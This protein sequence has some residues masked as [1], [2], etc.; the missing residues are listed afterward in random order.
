MCVRVC[1]CACGVGGVC[2]GHGQR[3][4]RVSFCARDPALDFFVSRCLVLSLISLTYTY[5]LSL[6]FSPSLSLTH[7]GGTLENLLEK[8]C[9]GRILE[10]D[11]ARFCISEVLCGLDFLHS[12]KI[13]YRDLKPENIRTYTRLRARVCMCVCVCVARGW[14][15]GRRGE[16]AYAA[17][18]RPCPRIA[19]RCTAR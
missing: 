1:V 17:G 2:A 19:A 10:E 3:A 15:A 14:G 7:S 18:S 5:T 4:G 13:I 11:A 6:A 12:R 9:P 16:G 8:C